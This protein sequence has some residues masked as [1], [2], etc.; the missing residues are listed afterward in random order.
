MADPLVTGP[1]GIYVGLPGTSNVAAQALTIA[2]G[3]FTFP[4]GA[5][6]PAGATGLAASAAQGIAAALANLNNPL[7]L[8]TGMRGPRIKVRRAYSRVWNDLTGPELAFDKIW[9]GEEALIFFDLTRWNENIYQLM[10]T[11]PRAGA[12]PGAEPPG[13]RGTLLMTEGK[14]FPLYLRFPAFDFHPRFKAAGGQAGYRFLCASIEEDDY[15]TGSGANMR[16]LALHCWEVYDPKSNGL[17]LYD[18]NMTGIGP[19]LPN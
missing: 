18:G 3:G 19:V 6:G 9:A 11:R 16:H 2:A 7:L 14:A 4:G 13:T 17:A 15:E 5:A 1:V 12:T 10:A 8:G